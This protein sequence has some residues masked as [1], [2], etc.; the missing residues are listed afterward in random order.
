M[1]SDQLFAAQLFALLRTGPATVA[2][3][4]LAYDLAG[5]RTGGIL[6]TALAIKMIVYAFLAPLSGAVVPPRL[7]KRA[8]VVLDLVRG[9]AA[10]MRPFVN[11]L[12]QVVIP[13][14][15]YG[16]GQGN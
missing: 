5:D 3:A 13:G 14:P 9:G 12:R 16:L 8:L 15:R 1:H 10:L 4:L 11:E 2:L 6:G 7:R